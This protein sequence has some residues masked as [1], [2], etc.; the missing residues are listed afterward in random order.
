MRQLQREVMAPMVG[1]R[2]SV[3]QDLNVAEDRC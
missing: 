2:P 1:M 3:G